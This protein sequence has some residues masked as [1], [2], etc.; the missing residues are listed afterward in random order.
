[1]TDLD[2][3]HCLVFIRISQSLDRGLGQDIAEV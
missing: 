3:S 1:M 2:F